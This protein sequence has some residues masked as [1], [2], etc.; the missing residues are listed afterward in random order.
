[1]PLALPDRAAPLARG[2]AFALVVAYVCFAPAH[3]YTPAFGSPHLPDWAMF[4]NGGVHQCRVRFFTV[5][6]GGA[7]QPVDRRNVLDLDRP[8]RSRRDRALRKAKAVRSQA[9]QLCKRL[10]VDD[11]RADAACSALEGWKQVYDGDENL[12]PKRRPKRRRARGKR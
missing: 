1:M 10:H 11:L 3:W 2:T 5:D 9:R 6:P 8:G 12:C 4:H 7:L